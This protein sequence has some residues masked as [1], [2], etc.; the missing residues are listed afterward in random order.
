VYQEE[1][2]VEKAK[3]AGYRVALSQ[4]ELNR[5]FSEKKLPLLALLADGEMPFEMDR[6]N[7]SGVLTEPPPAPLH[8]LLSSVLSLLK[9]PFF[10]LLESSRV[11]MALHMHD[12]AAAASEAAE[13]FSA[14]STA[15][16]FAAS[17]SAD[18]LVAL[19]ADH[20]TGGLSLG[21]G[22]YVLDASRIVHVNASAEAMAH[23]IF[24]GAEARGVVQRFA[25][26]NLTDAELSDFAKAG[27]D[28]WA[29]SMA[30]GNAVSKRAS[31]IWGTPSHTAADVV[32]YSFTK[33]LKS[34]S[35]ELKA[36]PPVM[37]NTALPK[38]IAAMTGFDLD[39]ITKQLAGLNITKP[40]H[41]FNTVKDPTH[42]L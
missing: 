16:D 32:L 2:L 31:I 21:A 15:L 7:V 36:V 23:L 30:I 13:C 34:V 4:E 42:D 10:L 18:T 6:G 35:A 3:A 14:V 1:G 29:A 11:D 37:E 24:S 27:S 22:S 28:A 8:V 5:A 17:S 9:P 40:A 12:A 25:G 38:W 19:V 33:Y 39:A 20:D 26:V 41:S